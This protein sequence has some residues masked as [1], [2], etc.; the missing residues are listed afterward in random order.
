[1]LKFL[2]FISKEDNVILLLDA[3]D[4]TTNKQFGDFIANSGLY[5]LIGSHIG[6]HNTATYI[7]GTK[8]ILDPRNLQCSGIS[9]Q[10]RHHKFSG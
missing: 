2:R 1:M 7:R 8:T 9:H 4:D 6:E 10:S 5:D 3:N